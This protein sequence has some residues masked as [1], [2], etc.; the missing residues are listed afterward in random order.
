[1]AVQ[2][3][4]RLARFNR[5]IT[6][7]I[8][9]QWAWLLPPWVVVCHRGRRSGRVYRTPVIAFKRGRTLAIAVLYGE[10]SD[11]VRNALAGGARMVRAGRTYELINTRVM[12][13]GAA[14]GIS[15]LGRVVG[16]LSGRVLVASLGDAAPGFGRG[17]AAG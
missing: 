15:P 4:R 3:P 1:M 12:D 10:E 16:R 8:Q 13:A 9:D 17:P 14:G 7:P 6:N 5:V 2:L 11:W